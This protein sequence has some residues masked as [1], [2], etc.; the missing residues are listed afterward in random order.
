MLKT[1]LFRPNPTWCILHH[2]LETI[3]GNFQTA[4]S[5]SN[6]WKKRNDWVSKKIT[7]TNLNRNHMA[8]PTLFHAV[9]TQCLAAVFL[10][11]VCFLP[12]FFPG[13][14]QFYEE[15][16]PI[17]IGPS[18]MSGRFSVWIMW[19]GNCRDVL[20]SAETFQGLAPFSSF[21]LGFF[22]SSQDIHPP[23]E[24]ELWVPWL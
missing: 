16:T 2:G 14:S 13:E 6:F 19:T 18:T 8:Y 1:F 23:R 21:I 5:D 17:W 22:V 10:L 4:A 20:R 12:V 7:T 9:G 3:W 11:L 24:A 15:D